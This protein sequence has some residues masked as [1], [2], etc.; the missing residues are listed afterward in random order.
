VTFQVPGYAVDGNAQ[1]GNFL[2]LMLQSATL[3]SQGVVGGQDCQVTATGVPSAGI[4][5]TSG[6]VVIVGA[7]ASFQGSYYGYNAGNDTTLTIAATGGSARSDMIIARAEDPTWSGSPWGNP[8][9]GQIVFPRVLSGVS[10]GATTVPGGYSAIALARIDVP[11]STS[12]ITNA[13]I[14]DLRTVANPQQLMIMEAHNPSSPHASTAGTTNVQWPT[15]AIWSVAIPAWATTF[16]FSW[17]VSEVLYNN[18][19]NLFVRGDVWPIFG[20]SV[21]SPAL[22]TP[23]TLVSIPAA[24]GPWRH[25]FAG[26]GT[27]SIPAS[28]RGTTQTLQFAQVADG[29]NTATLNYDAGAST[30]LIGQFQQLASAA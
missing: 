5:I 9:S 25:T 14:H 26:G 7:E 23:Q 13:M 27:I 8:A 22:T 21:T 29:T 20:S 15:G 17:T 30:T 6:A 2:R 24:A 3:G 11:A 28:M 18:D 19:G 10:S 4:I 16:V 1:N 12:A